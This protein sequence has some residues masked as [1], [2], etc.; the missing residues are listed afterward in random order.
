MEVFF[1]H[2]NAFLDWV[3]SGGILTWYV[4]GGLEVF[5]VDVFEGGV[6]DEPKVS[7]HW[8]TLSFPL[9]INGNWIP[10]WINGNWILNPEAV[11]CFLQQSFL[12]CSREIKQS[13]VSA[14]AGARHPIPIFPLCR[15]CFF[16]CLS[17]EGA[18]GMGLRNPP[19]S[20]FIY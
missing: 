5:P 11:K 10:L 7:L 9:W 17:K 4:K 18:F 19:S 14:N 6:I 1:V 12:S 20:P 2:E 16:S 13:T 8:W 15:N 3:Y